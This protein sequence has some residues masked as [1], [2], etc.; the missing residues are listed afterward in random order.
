MFR[1]KGHVGLSARGV[2]GIVADTWIARM[3]IG[4]VAFNHHLC[5]RSKLGG[6]C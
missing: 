1:L 5:C 2:N 3:A 6:G 4:G